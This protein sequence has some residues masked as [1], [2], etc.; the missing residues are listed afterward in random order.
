MNSYIF[1]YQI[2]LKF[3]TYENQVIGD[4]REDLKYCEDC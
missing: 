1:S 2:S 3:K 4:E